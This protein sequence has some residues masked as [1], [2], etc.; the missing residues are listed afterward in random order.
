[1]AVKYGILAM[2]GNGLGGFAKGPT[3]QCDA[4]WSITYHGA[5]ASSPFNTTDRI[6]AVPT[7]ETV[8]CFKFAALM[9]FI[10]VIFRT[11]DHDYVTYTPH[12]FV[13]NVQ[14]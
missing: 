5:P 9:A 12:L 7:S 3:D 13:Y 8:F 11:D 10:S 2:W 14:S 6:L 4:F 1:M